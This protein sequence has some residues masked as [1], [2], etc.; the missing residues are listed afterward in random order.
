M[1]IKKNHTRR[2]LLKWT[3]PIVASVLLPQHARASQV[4][5]LDLSID[6]IECFVTG[7]TFINCYVINNE[8]IA[9]TIRK[10]QIDTQGKIYNVIPSMPVVNTGQIV[11]LPIEGSSFELQCISHA[12]TITITGH[13]PSES[14]TKIQLTTSI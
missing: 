14:D 3:P 8:P 1:K 7:R 9:I 5:F 2:Q 6:R 10:V 12:I 4:G 11:K 13:R